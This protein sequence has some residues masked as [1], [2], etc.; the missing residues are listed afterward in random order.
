MADDVRFNV[1]TNVKARGFVEVA[2]GFYLVQSA[3][4]L[5]WGGVSL[6]RR[7]M[8]KSLDTFRE[9]EIGLIQVGKVAGIEGERL[10]SMGDDLDYLRTK[11]AKTR[12]DV[13][14]S[15]VAAARLGLQDDQEITRLVE[16]S[17]RLSKTSDLQPND[18]V[19]ILARSSAISGESLTRHME[20]VANVISELGDNVAASESEISGLHLE[21]L[22]GTA[23]WETS[24]RQAAAYAATLAEFNVQAEVAGT[25]MGKLFR[26]MEQG[27]R[28]P[29]SSIG[30]ALQELTGMD[31]KQ[32]RTLYEQ[33]PSN[34]VNLVMQTIGEQFRSGEGP[35]PYVIGLMAELGLQSERQAK[36]LLPMFTNPDRFQKAMEIA[37]SQDPAVFEKS[38]RTERTAFHQQKAFEEHVALFRRDIGEQLQPHM[39]EFWISMQR[40]LSQQDPQVI[41]ERFANALELVL[42][43]IE[44]GAS[45]L[46]GVMDFMDW[47]G[48]PA[49][50]AAGGYGAFR[51]VKAGGKA[52]FGKPTVEAS[53]GRAGVMDLTV[54]R[55]GMFMGPYYDDLVK[56]EADMRR[57]SLMAVEMRKDYSLSGMNEEEISSR[58]GKVFDE[59]YKDPSKIAGYTDHR[60]FMK[61]FDR[62]WESILQKRDSRLHYMERQANKEQV[63][64]AAKASQDVAEQSGSRDVLKM[65]G[66]GGAMAGGAALLAPGEAEASGL[67]LLVKLAGREGREF[68]SK[69]EAWDYVLD[70]P[71]LGGV[72]RQ[73]EEVLWSGRAPS[74][75]A[76]EAQQ[77]ARGGQ[78]QYDMPEAEEIARSITGQR[79]EGWSRFQ[80]FEEQLDN[81]FFSDDFN[82]IASGEWTLIKHG[83]VVEMEKASEM[84]G[85]RARGILQAE[86]AY[87]GQRE[88]T[89][90]LGERLEGYAAEA[91]RYT[92]EA[93]SVH[94]RPGTLAERFAAADADVAASAGRAAPT[95][96]SMEEALEDIRQRDFEEL[97]EMIGSQPSLAQGIPSGRGRLG[98]SPLARFLEGGDLGRAGMSPAARAA[99]EAASERRFLSSL[100]EF[101]GASMEDLLERASTSYRTD[102]AARGRTAEQ[103]E[104]SFA[105][106]SE[107][108]DF[109]RAQRAR[110]VA[111]AGDPSL[112]IP[113]FLSG[114]RSRAF[115]PLSDDQIES[116]SGRLIEASKQYP[117]PVRREWE[118]IADSLGEINQKYD[119]SLSFG[120]SGDS[121]IPKIL[122]RLRQQE[123]AGIGR[124]GQAAIAGAGL[125]GAGAFLGPEE[126]EAQSGRA[127][128]QQVAKRMAR[129]RDPHQ[130]TPAYISGGA[131]PEDATLEQIMKHTGV[132][133]LLERTPGLDPMVFQGFPGGQGFWAMAQEEQGR[134]VGEAFLRRYEKSKKHGTGDP[135]TPAMAG[136]D[137]G[138][139][140]LE[141]AVGSIP[142]VIGIELAFDAAARRLGLYDRAGRGTQALGA[143]LTRQGSLLGR[144]GAAG[145]LLGRIPAGA[146]AIIGGTGPI[147][148]GIGGGMAAWGLIKGWAARADRGRTR[149]N[150]LHQIEQEAFRLQE[151]VDVA[152]GYRGTRAE[153]QFVGDL[154]LREHSIDTLVRMGRTRG[155]AEEK[156]WEFLGPSLGLGGTDFEGDFGRGFLKAMEEN[157]EFK[158]RLFEFSP[159]GGDDALIRVISDLERKISEQNEMVSLLASNL[160]VRKEELDAILAGGF[161]GRTDAGYTTL[162]EALTAA[163]GAGI[164]YEQGLENLNAVATIMAPFGKDRFRAVDAKLPKHLAD[165]FEA[166]GMAQSTIDELTKGIGFAEEWKDAPEP[167]RAY[168]M[169]VQR[170][171]PDQLEKARDMLARMDPRFAA[172]QFMQ[173]MFDE[174]V[175]PSYESWGRAGHFEW[176]REH[177][178]QAMMEGMGV[179]SFIDRGLDFATPDKRIAKNLEELDESYEIALDGIRKI[180][181]KNVITPEEAA[182]R[183]AEVDKAYENIRDSMTG[184]IDEF[185]DQARSLLPL[186]EQ[187]ERS[188]EDL[189]ELRDNA[190]AIAERLFTGTELS[191]KVAAIQRSFNLQVEAIGDGV[192]DSFVDAAD[193]FRPTAEQFDISAARIM[194]QYWDAVSVEGGRTAEID[195]SR[196]L[197]LR[198]LREGQ[199]QDFMASAFD[200]LP[201]EEQFQELVDQL[202]EETELTKTNIERMFSEGT[203]D[204]V[205]ALEDL[206]EADR[207]YALRLKALQVQFEE[208]EVPL[209]RPAGVFSGFAYDYTELIKERDLIGRSRAFA[210]GE[211]AAYDAYL[212]QINRARLDT[213][214]QMGFQS[215]GGAV[216]VI[217]DLNRLGSAIPALGQLPDL[218]RDMKQM[219]AMTPDDMRAAGLT[220]GQ[221]RAQQVATG[222]AF[223]STIG[224]A[225]GLAAERP[226]AGLGGTLG[227]AVGSLWGPLGTLIGTLIGTGLGSL[228][229]QGKD[230]GLASIGGGY[231]TWA[232]MTKDEKGLGGAAKDIGTAALQGFED[233]LDILN[234]ELSG[235]IPALSI[236][237]RDGLYTIFIGNYRGVFRDAND[238]IAAAIQ[239]LLSYSDFQGDVG[240]NARI[241]TQGRFNDAQEF[242]RAVSAIAKIAEFERELNFSDAGLA[243]DDFIR[244]IKRAA[245]EIDELGGSAA[246]AYAMGGQTI[247]DRFADFRG[248]DTRYDEAQRYKDDL[249]QQRQDYIDWLLEQ[250]DELNRQAVERGEG[251]LP[252]GPP[253][254]RA[255][256]ESWDEWARDLEREYQ[257]IPEDTEDPALQRRRED[258]ELLLDWIEKL[259]G[260]PALTDA[261]ARRYAE[262]ITRQG[263]I[264][265]RDSFLARMGGREL[266][267][268]GGHPIWRFADGDPFSEILLDFERDM[269]QLDELHRAFPGFSEELEKARQNLVRL[270][271]EGLADLGNQ[272]LGVLDP[273]WNFLQGLRDGLEALDLLRNNADVLQQLG[274]DPSE[275]ERSGGVWARNNVLD[276]SRSLA[277]AIGNQDILN[278]LQAHERQLQIQDYVQRI[279]WLRNMGVVSG[280]VADKLKDIA[281]VVEESLGDEDVQRR[282]DPRYQQS[283]D[284]RDQLR[285]QGDAPFRRSLQEYADQVATIR[286]YLLP[287]DY[288]DLLPE[289][290]MSPAERRLRIDYARPYRDALRTI[291]YSGDLGYLSPYDRI[292]KLSEE[293]FGIAGEGVLGSRADELPGLGEN[294]LREMAAAYPVGSA[295]Y[296]AV[297]DRV[298]SVLDEFKTDIEEKSLEELGIEGNDLLTQLVNL[299]E[300]AEEQLREYWGELFKLLGD[301]LPAPDRPIPDGGTRPQQPPIGQPHKVFDPRD[302]DLTGKV[303]GVELSKRL[304]ALKIHPADLDN[305]GALSESEIDRWVEYVGQWVGPDGVIKQIPRWQKWLADHGI[306]THISREEF[307]H[308]YTEYDTPRPGPRVPWYVTLPPEN[309][310]T[311]YSTRDFDLSGRVGGV[312]LKS[313]FDY[314]T[315]HPGDRD[316]SGGLSQWEVQKW[317]E[318]VGR[319]LD[320][321]GNYIDVPY[322]QKWLAEKGA[323]DHLSPEE[324][325]AGFTP[326]VIP[327]PPGPR[328]DV[329]REPIPPAST[330]GA[331]ATELLPGLSESRSQKQI[332]VSQEQLVVL[333]KL[334]DVAESQGRVV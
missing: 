19:R 37:F 233:A 172:T 305:S 290:E 27:V 164:S 180:A 152:P 258:L 145:G 107:Q 73:G 202:E 20:S 30:V 236:K 87:G 53:M 153:K 2:S 329:H 204:S 126:A 276:V 127:F 101:Q 221:A 12:K 118:K 208:R 148:L 42:L 136:L 280:E 278:E 18:G 205:R 58:M 282:L 304:S 316:K 175:L 324:F 109:F 325:L 266:G 215:L 315:H 135:L 216:G 253:D 151:L 24:Q 191:S 213:A 218:W 16:L 29:T 225:V 1:V 121:E 247:L 62:D 173:D 274:L 142:G 170:P 9:Y 294:L 80:E 289:G 283:I 178:A 201:L 237:V 303:G 38:A 330:R 199:V 239:Q 124:A 22:K 174:A 270:K 10:R 301:G 89:Q 79:G 76:W 291:R 267:M 333:K 228:V 61:D 182:A 241:L 84:F 103:I 320:D 210:P 222:A 207:R 224:Q 70:N 298:A 123:S 119:L 198:G 25:A 261:D 86:A 257:A 323:Y 246:A 74:R 110:P 232:Y 188:Y 279:E 227:G 75:A 104:A 54:Q 326:Y 41:A 96:V 154:N 122:F 203:I 138:P 162:G 91:R 17:L 273:N 65:L 238:A 322:W 284:I 277:Q 50:I 129:E 43:G 264:E 252:G 48:T 187:M 51:G 272:L 171:D 293:F 56:R 6:V 302:I 102:L 314:L 60:A 46:E 296:Q 263:E 105:R 189:A 115:T 331:F 52:L 111:E 94:G 64:D 300:K 14:D 95:R 146:R 114:A 168:G 157:E 158:N 286:K 71:G 211:E 137:E 93:V 209:P 177:T 265:D 33:S 85:E 186:G 181:A 112:V 292:E 231:G 200:L 69:R 310:D 82:N 99:S 193:G 59:M 163:A 214:L 141:G 192:V 83:D 55:G 297:H 132:K 183:T 275:I 308:G 229:K 81:A 130:W 161:E 39:S 234:L 309:P 259:T 311:L 176:R 131:I 260:L 285:Y 212:Q 144:V 150:R 90:A 120:R 5:A 15:A 159:V 116:L 34:V 35:R 47:F 219:A 269:L 125:L 243:L 26:R 245:R 328:V 195:L 67:R 44:K 155:F 3:A 66:I 319:F 244:D 254:R 250:Y 97:L 21:V 317:T 196:D 133:G 13:Y 321:S 63:K 327:K 334:L 7:E 242:E 288:A 166:A 197:Q 78:F 45:M 271:N 248:W 185:I 149:E 307:Q 147:G 106:W 235:Q 23:A 92:Q 206:A 68:A 306:Y 57:S 312:E 249:N 32:L 40:I 194:E 28:F 72:V 226:Y 262:G 179:T 77:M 134:Q 256:R 313:M 98:A 108:P 117:E 223:G 299:G 165:V 100:E 139:G 160:S 190:I 156:W 88:A 240:Y 140:F 8:D 4:Q 281:Q 318:I 11:L 31:A 217:P 167:P 184:G 251:G 230:E 268:R 113:E 220:P 255:D 295:P 143:H 332:E 287:E 128:W 49:L 169:I 36:A